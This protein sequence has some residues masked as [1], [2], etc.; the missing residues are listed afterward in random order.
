MIGAA[1]ALGGCGGPP[2]V[3]DGS[4]VVLRPAN[5]TWQNNPPVTGGTLY[6]VLRREG[7]IPKNWV[8][9]RWTAVNLRRGSDRLLIEWDF[10]GCGNRDFTVFVDETPS[11]VIV[12]LWNDPDYDGAC[13]AVAYRAATEVKL[14]AP[15]G[16][17]PLLKH[18]VEE[19][20]AARP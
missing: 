5:Q 17:R 12:D 1:L 19:A 14:A 16:Q 11:R 4:V 8:P 10:G 15:L 2:T 20:P 6:R 7:Q 3:P 9:M 13:A 18:R